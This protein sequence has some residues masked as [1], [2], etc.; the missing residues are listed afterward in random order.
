MSNSQRQ[1]GNTVPVSIERATRSKP[2][3]RDVAYQKIIDELLLGRIKPGLLLTQRELCAATDS[4]LGA[5]REA[6]KRLEAE[7]I[8]SLI[9]QRGVMV[10]EPSVKEITDLYEFR[11]IIEPHAVRVYAES[12]D[13][14]KIEDIKRQ[15]LSILDRKATTRDEVSDLSRQRVLVDDLFHETLLRGLGNDAVDQVFQKFR[16][17]SQISRLAVQPR[18]H[19]SRPGAHEHLVIIEALERR[20]A[21][22]AA[23][24][25]LAHLD[26]GLL[27]AIGL[28]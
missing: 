26:R 3:L 15:T 8:I 13:L 27:R 10:V 12:G 18:F 23:K 9:P 28:E 22:A 16:L 4:N 11:K 20:D 14:K 21:E 6:L 1:P 24:A 5:M 19:D 17:Q 2:V 7:G 25:M